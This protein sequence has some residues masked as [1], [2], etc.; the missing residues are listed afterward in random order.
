MSNLPRI[1]N[2]SLKFV[3][4][5][6]KNSIFCVIYDKENMVAMGFI[7]DFVEFRIDEKLYK[8]TK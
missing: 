6:E 4:E 3:R 7:S 1:P 5:S 8:R 2:S